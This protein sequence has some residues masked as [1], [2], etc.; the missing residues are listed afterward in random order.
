ML[1]ERPYITD[2]RL[3]PR[4]ELEVKVSVRT[5]RELLT[6]RTL[7]INESGISAV[8][9]GELDKG[10]EA[11]LQIGVPGNAVTA[12]AIVRSRNEFRH[13][14]ELVPSGVDTR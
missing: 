10:E 11:E 12:R 7:D 9:P 14:F 13:G 6:G 5:E 4:R 1:I 2:R 3:H 8:L